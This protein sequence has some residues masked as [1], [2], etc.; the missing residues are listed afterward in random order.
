M[1]HAKLIRNAIIGSCFLALIALD[2]RYPHGPYAAFS[3]LMLFA[4]GWLPF[5]KFK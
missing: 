1:K 4:I 2:I 5:S 3:L